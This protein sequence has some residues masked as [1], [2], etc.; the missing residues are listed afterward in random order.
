MEG[1]TWVLADRERLESALDA[2]VE[3]AVKATAAGGLI[4]LACRRRGS[5]VE[6]T[7]AD[8]GPGISDEDAAFVFVRFWKRPSPTG[9]RGTGLGLAYLKSVAEAHGGRVMLG[10]SLEGG[11]VVGL[12]LACQDG[13]D[14]RPGSE[15]PL[16]ARAS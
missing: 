15:S 5:E 1:V 9:E 14:G 6:L 7:V 4:R 16:P 11:A 2:L 13:P 10:H 3:N 8:D 12:V